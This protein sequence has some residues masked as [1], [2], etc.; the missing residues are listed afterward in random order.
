M[1]PTRR[2][3]PPR[4]KRL[5]RRPPS[6]TDLLPWAEY[7]PESRA[8][9]LEDGISIG[10]L[11]EL[12]PV[13]T[14][15]RTPRFMAGLRDAI[16]TALTD[17]IPEREDA[18]WILQVYVQD[19]PSLKAFSRELADYVH[20]DARESAFSRHFQQTL[21]EHLE[22]I[23]RPGGL[24][25]DEAVTG[26]RWR[27]QIRRVRAVLYRRIRVRGRVPSALEVEADLN[28]V[29]TK[30]VA[31]L[32]AAGIKAQA[33]D[34]GGPLPLAPALVQP[35]TGGERRRRGTAPG[36]RPLSRRR[37]PALRPRPGRAPDPLDAGVRRRDAPPGGS[38]A[39]RTP[40]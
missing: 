37:G 35:E 12:T 30:W 14:E 10:A 28:D 23:S 19:A 3:G 15:A 13:G 26:T 31:A 34:R 9:L 39:C 38:T 1:P 11:F 32:A 25:T 33:R 18:P 5:Y 40:R 2:S 7:L 16:Q 20:P 24:F 21:A 22:R 36:G 8:F 4:S 29:A 17:A 27:G 6:F